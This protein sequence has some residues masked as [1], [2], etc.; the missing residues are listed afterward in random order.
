MFT[1]FHE[2]LALMGRGLSF[3][4]D[5][6]P[7]YGLAIIL[8][9]VAVR[10][11]MLPLTIK[12]TRSMQEMQKLQPEVKRLQAKYKGGDRQKMN[13]EMMKLY[14]E[15]KVNPLGG[16]LPL[17]LQLPIFLALYRVFAGCGAHNVKVCPI[18]EVGTK[19]L[20]TGSALT[21]AIDSGKAGFLGM[22]LGLAP[23]AALKDAGSFP[24]SLVHV[25]PYFLLILL[26]VG[27]TW[28]QQKQIQAVSTGQQAQQM[29]MMGKIMPL[30]LGVF[31]L[32]LPA[33]VS[34]YWVAS[35]VW[36]IVQ[37][38]FILGKTAT[39]TS[40]GGAGPAAAGDAGTAA[41]KG[42][43]APAKSGG[44]LALLRE[45]RA[46]G[47]A[48]ARD[49]AT[50]KPAPKPQAK[51]AAK[52]TREDKN[53]PAEREKTAARDRPTV[54]PKPAPKPAAGGA[55]AAPNRRR[56]PARSG[57]APAGAKAT[58]DGKAKDASAGGNGTTKP[59]GAPG[60][61]NGKTPTAGGKPVGAGA[62]A[63]PRNTSA[64]KRRR[65]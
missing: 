2:L 11:V 40:P 28:Y 54:K 9:T 52:D 34:I 38:R 47:A 41:G 43:D 4:Y 56:P 65:R 59:G 31:S 33:G 25:L 17:L 37:Q 23:M 35:N 26:M 45:Q 51:P 12:Q 22:N 5:L 58:T 60:E 18:T 50:A 44:L 29:Q 16:C 63:R 21:R 14:K 20:P 36:T 19:Y 62:S 30:V 64:K 61:S 42:S 55:K 3:F 46:E 49:K 57:N 53:K 27:T 6:V 24:G 7:S 15:H 10:L 48:A 8:L 39:A 1:L 13:E 32:N